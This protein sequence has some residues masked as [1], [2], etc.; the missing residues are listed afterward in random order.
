MQELHRRH[1]RQ[2]FGERRTNRQRWRAVARPRGDEDGEQR[3]LAAERQGQSCPGCGWPKRE[4]G[5]GAGRIRVE[6]PAP[7]GTGE[8][9]AVF[10]NTWISVQSAAA[11]PKPTRNPATLLRD[12]A[13]L[14]EWFPFA[15]WRRHA[16]EQ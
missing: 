6:A 2:G 7:C 8:P 5:P 14:Q 16:P 10:R 3:G 9:T 1:R 15:K 12:L 11:T 4:E 13:R